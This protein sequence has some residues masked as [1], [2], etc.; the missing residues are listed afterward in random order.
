MHSS[1]TVLSNRPLLQWLLAHGADP[2]VGEDPHPRIPRVYSAAASCVDPST[3]QLLLSYNKDRS[4]IIASQPLHEAAAGR[5][6]QLLAWLIDQSKLRLD[7][8]GL[9]TVHPGYVKGTPLHY[10]VEDVTDSEKC[11]ET[12]Q[13]LLDRGADVT[14]KN[15]LGQMPI[16]RVQENY[17][18]EIPESLNSIVKLLT[19]KGQK[20]SGEENKCSML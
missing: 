6:T 1:S 19:P 2:D 14:K 9:D 3:F 12:V 13:A 7:V 5:N 10:A 16:D 11:I 17:G 18:G 4:L 8:N 15:Q 20:Q